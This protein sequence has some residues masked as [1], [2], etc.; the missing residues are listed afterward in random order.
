MNKDIQLLSK[1]LEQVD[2][3]LKDREV[4]HKEQLRQLESQMEIEGE[5]FKAERE[6]YQAESQLT[7]EALAEDHEQKVGELRQ[8]IEDQR[9]EQVTKQGK[10]LQEIEHLHNL[11]NEQDKH[12]MGWSMAVDFI[13]QGCQRKLK[14]LKESET[15]EF[16][17]VLQVVQDV[18]E[19]ISEEMRKSEANPVVMDLIPKINNLITQISVQIIQNIQK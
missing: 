6:K 9:K 5:K 2:A 15:T 4:E 3:N 17:G 8:Q 13:L 11:I 18:D 7:L 1:D 14:G 19:A 12:K 16:A 10:Y